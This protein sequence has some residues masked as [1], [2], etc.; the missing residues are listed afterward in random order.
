MSWHVGQTC[1]NKPPMSANIQSEIFKRLIAANFSS[2]DQLIRHC[3]FRKQHSFVWGLLIRMLENT[4]NT[5]K[6]LWTTSCPAFKLHYWGSWTPP[7]GC[8]RCLTSSWAGS[9]WCC[10][11]CPLRSTCIR[12]FPGWC[13]ERWRCPSP[14]TGRRWS[15]EASASCFPG[16]EPAEPGGR[17][18]ECHQD[19]RL[20]QRKNSILTFFNTFLKCLLTFFIFWLWLLDNIIKAKFVL[21]NLLCARGT[22]CVWVV[23]ALQLLLI[24]Q[25]C[26]ILLCLQNLLIRARETGGNTRRSC[27]N[28]LSVNVWV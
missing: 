25:R 23:S 19:D 26:C 2:F 13:R 21:L 15:S 24:E 4:K 18:A 9:E 5:N 1:H 22:E 11:L 28:I 3:C 8:R 20:R 17:Q 27:W 7:S 6:T 14:D 16:E 10:H 12:W